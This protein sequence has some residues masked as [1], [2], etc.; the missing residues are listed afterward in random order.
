MQEL[1]QVIEFVQYILD[2]LYILPSKIIRFKR[3]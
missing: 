2:S 3:K 1:E